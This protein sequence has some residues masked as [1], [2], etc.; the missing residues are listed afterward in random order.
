MYNDYYLEQINNKMS[1]AN[2]NIEELIEKQETIIT[3]Q[4]EIISG[5]ILLRQNLQQNTNLTAIMTLCTVM[6]FIYTFIV[7]CLK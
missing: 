5:E 7:R 2:S 6:A 1:I 4:Q 3:Q